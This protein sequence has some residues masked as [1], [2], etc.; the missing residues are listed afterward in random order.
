MKKVIALFIGVL[1]FTACEKDTITPDFEEINTQQTT[2]SKKGSKEG[3]VDVCHKEKIINVSV[4]ALSGHQGHGDAI[5][6]DGDGYFDLENN[7][8]EMDCDDSNPAINPGAEEILDDDLD[9]NCDGVS[10]VS[11]RDSDGDGISD[12]DDDCPEV[13]GLAAFNG[14]PDSDGDGIE[15][16]KDDCP[17]VAGLKSLN[18]CPDADGDGVSDADDTCPDEAGPAAN[19][20]CP[21]PD[22]DGDGVL[23]KDDVC[24][25]V[26]GTVANN[27]CPE[28]EVD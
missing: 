8:S 18:G 22:T 23:D 4:N 5:D 15:D 26:P 21:W 7:C 16:S 10:E 2:F 6:M 11:N 9:N 25:D 17:T 20:G 24:P 13:A 19:N 3:K 1:L 27:G 12:S 14:C 28:V